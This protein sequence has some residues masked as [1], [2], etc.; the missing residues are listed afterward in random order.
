MV[1]GFFTGSWL[2]D[3]TAKIPGLEGLD[4]LRTKFALIDPIKD[5]QLALYIAIG[6]GVVTQFYG[7]ILRVWRDW[8]RGD[9]MGA[10]SDGMLWIGFLLF[11]ILG[12]VTGNAFFWALFLLC[13]VGLILTHGRDQ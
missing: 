6:I 7:M 13:V 2:G 12:A 8:R 1:V 4:A 3:L 10:F 5:S 9:K 11:V